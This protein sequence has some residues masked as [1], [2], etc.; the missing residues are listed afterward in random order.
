M[1]EWEGKPLGSLALKRQQIGFLNE[2][3]YL[4]AQERVRIER[5][6]L[7]ELA[8]VLG[9][10]GAALLDS[11]HPCPGSPIGHCVFEVT[12]STEDLDCLF[13]G[14]RINR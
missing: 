2:Q 7:D 12:L 6:F 4:L 9:R 5:S 10:P 14:G 1:R 13:C 3:I 8:E 11:H